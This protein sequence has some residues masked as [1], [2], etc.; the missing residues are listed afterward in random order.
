MPEFRNYDRLRHLTR[1]MLGRSNAPNPIR[2]AFKTHPEGADLIEFDE[3]MIEAS[4]ASNVCLFS[5][6]TGWP[7]EMQLWAEHVEHSRAEIDLALE[8]EERGIPPKPSVELL[9]VAIARF[10]ALPEEVRAAL[11]E[12]EASQQAI[13]AVE[14]YLDEQNTS[15]S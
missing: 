12:S 4:M 5:R 8:W 13:A 14:D 1:E 6:A 3:M 15:E 10:Q 9:E 11:W 2:E 7:P